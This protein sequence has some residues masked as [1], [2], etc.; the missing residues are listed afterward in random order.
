VISSCSYLYV[1]VA[2]PQ[3]ATFA[4]FDSFAGTPREIFG[5]LIRMDCQ[6]TDIRDAFDAADPFG[7]TGRRLTKWDKGAHARRLVHRV[8]RCRR[9]ELE[10]HRDQQALTVAVKDKKK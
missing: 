10:R 6:G 5:A 4:A 7:R 9:Q 2:V 3:R 8:P 1:V